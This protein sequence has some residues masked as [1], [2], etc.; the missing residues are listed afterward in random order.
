MDLPI[1]RRQPQPVEPV[2]MQ[3][4]AVVQGVCRRSEFGAEAREALGLE[5]KK[6]QPP[7]PQPRAVVVE[8]LGAG[9]PR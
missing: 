1:L 8:G 7:T 3:I 6:K 2:Q 9:G 4:E 5:K